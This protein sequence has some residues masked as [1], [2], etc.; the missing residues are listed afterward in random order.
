MVVRTLALGAIG[1]F[2]LSNA[3]AGPVSMTA[4][5]TYTQNFNTLISTGTGT[6]T[7]DATISSWYAKRSGTGTSIAAD[8]GSGTAGN[9]YSY[10]ASGNSD[11]AI[12]SIGSSNAAAG[13]FAWGVQLKNDSASAAT[14]GTVSYVGEQWRNGG[15]TTANVVTFWYKISSTVITDLTPA[16]DTGWTAITALNFSS[17]INTASAAALDG[18]AAA[19]RVSV[20][21][22]INLSIPAGNYVMFRWKDPDHSGTDHGL[23]TDDVSIA[24]TVAAAGPVITASSAVSGAVATTYGSPSASPAT[25]TVSGANM[26]AGVSIDPPAPFEVSTTSN[27]SSTVG[28]HGNPIVVGSTGTINSTIVYL[29][30]PGT[31]PVSGSPFSGNIVCSSSNATSA[32]VSTVSSTVSPATLTISGLTGANKVYDGATTASFTGTP[33]YAGLVNGDSFETVSGTATANFDS[34]NVGAVKTITVAGYTPPSANYAVT[35]PTLAGEITV[36]PLTVTASDKNKAFGIALTGGPGSTAFTS[37]GLALGD[38]ID[39]VTI[40]YGTGAGA[41]DM[42][43]TYPDQVFVADAVGAT[44]SAANYTIT[45]VPG[46]LLVSASPTISVSGTLSAVNTIYGTASVSPASFT[47]S[48]G[49]LTGDLTISAPAGFEVSISPASGYASSIP[50]V[51]TGGT[52]SSTTVYVRLTASTPVGTYSGEISVSGGGAMTQFISTVASTVSPKSVTITGVSAVDKIYDG[53]NTATLSGT[54]TLND[55]LAGD[56]GNVSVSGTPT[57]TFASVSV[58]SGTVVTVAGYMLDGTAAANYTPVQPTGLTASITQKEITV[59]GA[60]VVTKVYDG[61]TAATITGTLV[62]VVGTDDVTFH[63][64]GTFASPAVGSGIVVTSNSTITGTA[65]SNY[66]LTQP[67]GLTG[68]ITA[69]T[70]ANLSGLTMSAGILSPAFAAAT[71]SYS[72]AVAGSTTSMTLTP[73]VADVGATVTVNGAAVTSGTAS[74]AINLAAGL[75]AISVAVTA[76][77]LTTIKTYTINVTR[78]GPFTPGNFVVEKMGDGT[79]IANGSAVP[80]ALVEFAAGSNTPAQTFEYEFTGTNLLTESNNSTANGHPASYAGRLAV[81]GLNLA[82]GTV[83]ASAANAKATNIFDTEGQVVGRTLFPTG[84]PTGTPPSPFS[85][86]NMR[87]V[88]PVTANT[89]Y[90]SGTASPGATGGVWYYDGTAFTQLNPTL[91]NVRNIGI[92]NSQ[93]YVTSASGLNIGLSKVGTGLPTTAAQAITLDVATGSGSSPY[94]FVVFDTNNDGAAD[95][96]YIADDRSAAGAGLRRYDFNGTAWVNTYS[97]LFGTSNALSATTGVG[98]RGLAGSF[99]TATA[100]ATLVATTT[101]ASGNRIVSVV[102]SGTAPTTY[103]VMATAPANVVYRG[104]AAAPVAAP[105]LNVTVAAPASGVTNTNFDYTLTVSNTGDADAAGVAVDFTLP[106]GVSFVSAS[107]TDGFTGINN[108]GVVNFTGGAVST[109]ASATLTVTVSAAA[110]GTVTAPIGAAVVDPAHVITEVSET[111]NASA[112]AASTVIGA[113]PVFTQ[114]PTPTQTILSGTTATLTASADGTP[115]AT[116]QWYQ[117]ASGDTSTPLSGETGSSV[118]T[119]VLTATTSF[120]VQAT[121]SAGSTNSNTAIVIVDNGTVSFAASG[122]VSVNPLNINGQL[123]TVQVTLTRTVGVGAGSVTVKASA[124]DTVP[125]GQVKLTNT[126]DYTLAGNTGTVEFIDGATTAVL[127]IPLKTTVH[128]GRFQLDL[129]GVASGDLTIGTPSR[130]MIEVSKKDTTAPSVTLA[131][132]ALDPVSAGMVKVSG[133][134]TDG[135]AS[136]ASS[137]LYRVE[138]INVS[139]TGT[140]TTILTATPTATPNSYEYTQ[141]IQLDH[142]VNKLTVNA[143]DNSG[144]KGTKSLSVSFSNPAVTSLMGTYSGLLLPDASA[145]SSNDTLGFLTLK[146][147]AT[148]VIS[149][150]LTVGGVAVALSGALDNDGYVYFKATGT[151]YFTVID[152]TE[153]ESYLGALSVRIVGTTATGK[154]EK[155]GGGDVLANVSADL[156]AVAVAPIAGT[157]TTGQKYTVVFPSKSQDGIASGNYPQG[158]GYASVTVKP[159][160]SVSA[161]GALADGT[162]YSASGKLHSLVGDTQSVSLFSMLYK[163]KGAFATELVF[164]Q[165]AGVR[166]SSDVLGTD[167]KWIRPAQPRARYYPAGWPAGAVVDAT[168]SRFNVPITAT[169]VLPNLTAAIPNAQLQFESGTLASPLNLNGVIAPTN[170]FT[171]KS[172]DTALKLSISKST[173][174][175]TGTFTHSDN[176]KLAFKG[177]ITQ[178]G[179]EAGG[180]GFFLSTPPNVYNGTGFGGGVSLIALPATP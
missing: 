118:T 108:S 79:A 67:A 90:A 86:S 39:S 139:V 156:E 43:G 157:M 137:G 112:I 140:R 2:S 51:E 107:G 7:D 141:N 4:S 106:A 126:A 72:A 9:L 44:F 34:K 5:G 25:F 91:T 119:P 87:G 12:G 172:L 6:W 31:A 167:S 82:A 95:L 150:K 89:F 70:N 35:Q 50:L 177:I 71:T 161:T 10:G 117:G 158:D 113:L 30:L 1:L 41:N 160:G 176:S 3:N 114:Q 61:T 16:A 129:T 93:L 174:I 115:V 20:S 104:V 128:Y 11:R 134:I 127:S 154:L 170:A 18:N 64:T 148:G 169:S 151:K 81:P 24:Y 105:D 76:A 147:T 122:V 63:G 84:G 14:I 125:L 146:S 149:G 101:E 85:G 32:N 163:K 135:T 133:T 166:A 96:V 164:D 142:G 168:G 173:G 58:N 180:Y 77:D 124:P 153:F 59:S 46:D 8:S 42:A 102:D 111:N 98:I 28:T 40:T 132:L 29:R 123:N 88:V 60:T 74:Q 162:A 73:T 121:N 68:T 23:A 144:K 47:A 92:F 38:L 33:T 49:N 120:W 53:S 78:P 27:F 179:A 83:G 52:V 165:N 48:G 65:S 159:N 138:L 19:N 66:S 37:D 110:T 54:P 36:A 55:V 17:P 21:S 178:E 45:Y 130:L 136:A 100:T 69:S 143:S 145:V 116:Y 26:E 109:S 175:F 171:N 152:K 75:N 155:I 13:N 97:L 99:N 57:A 22:N 103:T 56:L 62:G 94:G 15:N 131:T 80:L